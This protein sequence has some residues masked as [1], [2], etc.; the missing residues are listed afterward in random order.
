MSLESPS[1][2]DSDQ[3]EKGLKS[4]KG[5]TSTFTDFVQWLAGLI[6]KRKWVEILMLVLAIAVLFFS[7]QK[8]IAN[9]FEDAE[10][11]VSLHS[12]DQGCEQYADWWEVLSED[13]ELLYRKVFE[14]SHEDE[15]PFSS[16]GG[17]IKIKE[18]QVVIVR[19]DLHTNGY[20]ARQAWKGTVKKGFK[21]I[22]LSENFAA[23]V[24]KEEPQ[25]PDCQEN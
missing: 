11:Y 13:S 14:K 3:I 5:L 15:Q 25:P 10:S 8:A 1:S 17:T 23:N 20:Q 7:S 24:A 16:S 19:A 22:R 18:D 12:P 4:V 21:F 6:R 9:Y 2:P